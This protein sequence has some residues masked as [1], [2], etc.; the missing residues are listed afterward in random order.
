VL[1][2]LEDALLLRRQ[3]NGRYAMHH[4]LRCFAAFSAGDARGLLDFCG[5]ADQLPEKCGNTLPANS[6][7]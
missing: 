4:L 6:S 1:R 2:E 5:E 3:A 7:R